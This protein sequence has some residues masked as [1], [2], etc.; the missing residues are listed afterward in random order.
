MSSVLI[1][2]QGKIRDSDKSAGWGLLRGQHQAASGVMPEQEVGMPWLP[3]PA[4]PRLCCLS[5]GRSKPFPGLGT[6]IDNP[7]CSAWFLGPLLWSQAKLHECFSAF[8]VPGWSPR[9]H[10]PDAR[11][12]SPQGDLCGSHPSIH[13]DPSD[14]CSIGCDRPTGY[15]GLS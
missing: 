9:K 10:L 15:H 5:A 3:G 13:P 1:W 12:R 2:I 8:S 4:L 7:G 11:Q 6:P 14:Q